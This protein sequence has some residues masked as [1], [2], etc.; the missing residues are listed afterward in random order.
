MNLKKN[1][2]MYEETRGLITLLVSV[3]SKREGV[4]WSIKS[5][6]REQVDETVKKFF[7]QCLK[8]LAPVNTGKFSDAVHGID[9]ARKQVRD[10]GASYCLVSFL[11]DLE[12]YSDR[13]C[14]WRI[15]R[16]MVLWEHLIRLN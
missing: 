16:M 11:T 5:K 7:E 8:S 10:A 6:F 1:K 3:A 12:F 4:P 13:W 2:S 9:L 14:G 15:T